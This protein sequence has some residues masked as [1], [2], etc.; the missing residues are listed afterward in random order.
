MFADVATAKE[1]LDE[2]FNEPGVELLLRVMYTAIGFES[3][4]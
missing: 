2:Y 4:E 3:I 1:I